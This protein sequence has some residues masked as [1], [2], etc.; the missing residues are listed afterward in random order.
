MSK[1][2]LNKV[3]SAILVLAI[4][5]TA[6]LGC[7]VSAETYTGSYTIV[8]SAYAEAGE[9]ADAKVKIKSENAFVAGIFT[10][11]A[12][13]AL[14]FYTAKV[15]AATTKEGAEKLYPD[16]HTNSDN[17][18]IL[19]QG[20]NDDGTGLTE[21]TEIEVLLTFKTTSL[22]AGKEYSVNIKDIDVTDIKEAV[23][24]ITGDAGF[25]H[26]HKYNDGVV[27]G[28]ITRYTCTKCDAVKTETT[29]S[30]VKLEDI[31]GED[32]GLTEVEGAGAAITFA[33]NG[34]IALDFVTVVPEGAT[35][36]LAQVDEEGNITKLTSTDGKIS[37]KDAFQNFYAGGV[38]TIADSI[39]ASFVV[40]DSEGNLVSKSATVSLSIADYC[41][42]VIDE[43]PESDDAK[44]CKA[45]LTY[46]KAASKYFDY[47]SAL[48][49]ITDDKY[50]DNNPTFDYADDVTVNAGTNGW[51]LKSAT[52]SLKV[53]PTITLGFEIDK[54][55][56]EN[57]AIKVNIGND[58]DFGKLDLKYDEKKDRYYLEI[59]DIDAANVSK[60]IVVTVNGDTDD[61]AEYSIKAYANRQKS[62][63]ADA[64]ML[65][66]LL[67][68]YS[69][70]LAAAD[71]S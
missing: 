64:A 51:K 71:F 6:F 8:G 33:P 49:D 65:A 15:V 12:D 55:K 68:V 24:S 30:D 37:G 9:F 36:Y 1:K 47:E 62:K 45:L 66:H 18:K 32:N 4:C 11:D 58:H 57:I 59:V 16:I 31:T 27:E 50:V 7:V 20:F 17:N 53:K 61:V 2:L 70:A 42:T 41:T 43:Y 52:I 3:I 54:A 46:A 35:V 10:V 28:D 40:A 19:F 38:K 60:D 67:V 29:K 5:S 26:V 21:Y 13:S 14:D 48:A 34:D 25:V 22:V 23:Y 39:N 69:D 63:D 44:Y 56:L